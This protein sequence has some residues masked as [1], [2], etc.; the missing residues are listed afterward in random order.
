MKFVIVSLIAVANC[1]WEV[2]HMMTAQVAKNQLKLISPDALAWAESLVK[3]FNSLTDGRSNTFVEAAVWADDI[4]ESGTSYLNNWHYIDRPINPDGL[5]IQMDPDTILTNSI[6]GIDR[7]QKILTN[8]K[9]VALR[10]TVFKAQM[11]RMLLH[12]I[13]DMH[14]PL[15]NSNY[16]NTTYPNGDQGGNLQ[17]IQVPALPNPSSPTAHSSTSTPS[18][19]PEPSA[20]SPTIPSWCALCSLPITPTWRSGPTTS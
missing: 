6:K 14:Q 4:K 19:M 20:C 15:H 1:W 10:H 17:K 18:G 7:A 8:T 12:I 3:D 5:L 11:I 2:G 16:Y 9:T 13:G